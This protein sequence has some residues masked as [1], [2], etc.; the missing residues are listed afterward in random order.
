MI[1]TITCEKVRR[2]EPYGNA[3]VYHS[4]CCMLLHEIIDSGKANGH[5]L[6]RFTVALLRLVVHPRKSCDYRHL[7][8]GAL[9]PLCRLGLLHGGGIARW[10]QEV[11]R[12]SFGDR[13]LLRRL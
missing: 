11:A 12:A 3:I 2:Y 10:A 9:R 4:K 8:P 7:Q 6:A 13:P 5:A 1:I